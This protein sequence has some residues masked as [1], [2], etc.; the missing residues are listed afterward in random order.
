MQ[1]A[2]ARTAEGDEALMLAWQAGDATAFDRLYERH[3]GGTFRYL[4]RQCGNRATAEELHQDVW[5]RLIGARASFDPQSRFTTWAYAVARNRLID[6]WRSHAPKRL[7][8]LDDT[9]ADGVAAIQ[10]EDEAPRANPVRA[11]SNLQQAELLLAALAALPAAQRDAFLLHVEG[12]LAVAE[13]AALTAA[14]AE[15]VK[16]RLRYAYKRLRASLGE[17]A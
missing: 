14:P 2:E 16:S 10:L 9:D 6:H 1:S 15:T 5:L 4:L 13:I 3:R 7:V 8:S 17:P 12:G 11:A